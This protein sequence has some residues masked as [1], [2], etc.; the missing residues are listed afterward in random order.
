[1]HNGDSINWYV[2]RP[3]QLSEIISLKSSPPTYTEVEDAWS[4]TSTVP[5]ILMVRC[6]IKYWINFI[7]LP[8]IELKFLM[9]SVYF[10][11]G[12]I[13]P[14]WFVFNDAL[15]GQ[16]YSFLSESVCSRRESRCESS[17]Y[18]VG[19]WH[20]FRT[21]VFKTVCFI[22]YAFEKLKQYLNELWLCYLWKWKVST[23]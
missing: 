9:Y 21:W 10:R 1:M 14:C 11:N 17:H 15:L 7:F 13:F 22:C 16:A 3:G 8:Y 23:Y 2:R 20:R 5:Y 6:L 4:Y 19:S 18:D 12:F